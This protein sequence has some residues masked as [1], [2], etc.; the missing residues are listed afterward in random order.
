M[1]R[2]IQSERIRIGLTQQQLADQLG[3][4]VNT[5]RTWEQGVSQ[6]SAVYLARLAIAFDCSADYLLGLTEERTIKK[7]EED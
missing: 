2:N 5:V 4:H 1:T 3:T 7:E 6:P